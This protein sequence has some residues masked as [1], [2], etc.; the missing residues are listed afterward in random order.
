[1]TAGDIQSALIGSDDQQFLLRAER[2][3]DGPGRVYTVV[4]VTTDSSN[5]A[6]TAEASVLVPH[7]Q[8][9]KTK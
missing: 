4:Y 6:S 2:D 5:N 3:G 7:D 9:G 1:M 8:G